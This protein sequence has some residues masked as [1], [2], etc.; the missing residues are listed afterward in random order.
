MD[1]YGKSMLP[2]EFIAQAIKGARTSRE[3]SQTTHKLYLHAGVCELFLL[4][5]Q[6]KCLV[7]R[8]D[9][10]GRALLRA[11]LAFHNSTHST[12]ILDYGWDM[13]R[14]LWPKAPRL[15]WWGRKE[16]PANSP[17][18]PWSNALMPHVLCLCESLFIWF[19]CP[20][21]LCMLC[22]TTWGTI[23]KRGSMQMHW[24]N[25]ARSLRSVMR[26]KS[27]GWLRCG[28]TTTWI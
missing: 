18:A 21:L 6:G 2:Q 17:G 25:S 8:C 23:W 9:Q 27:P 7:K 11:A 5:T 26:H 28:K 16:P 1:G 12:T 20:C 13:V 10:L 3:A 22:K 14:K 24:S 19:S 15:G 4:S